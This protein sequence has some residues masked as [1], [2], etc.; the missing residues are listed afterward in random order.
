LA[1]ESFWFELA[2]IGH[3]SVKVTAARGSVLRP[4]WFAPFLADRG[5][6]KL[7]PH[8]MKAYRQDFDAIAALIVG[9]KGDLAVMSLGDITTKA[10]RGAFA[11]Y[12]ETHKAAS[13][14]RCWST[15]NVLCAF[16]YTSDMIPANPMPLVGRPK[17][18]KTLPKGLPPTSV[19]ALLAAVDSESERRASNW[20]E[21]DRALILTSLLAGLRAD[22]LL[23][24]NV[25][26]VRRRD[27][28][29][30][31]QVR[32]KGGKDRSTGRETPTVARSFRWNTLCASNPTTP[33]NSS[34]SPIAAPSKWARWPIST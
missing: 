7:S 19:Q 24:A 26:D 13:I 21:R 9:S 33:P 28:G 3:Q 11:Q 1:L 18:A 27:D 6:R 17:I 16:L 29:A 32:G 15:W 8:T 30:I 14:Q 12:A 5:T 10:M 22:E 2:G 23:R 25:G 34:A 20:M 4:Q 31:I